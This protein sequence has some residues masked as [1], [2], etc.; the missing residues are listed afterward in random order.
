MNRKRKND[1]GG[2]N[3]SQINDYFPPL[4]R[5]QY[6]SLQ[7]DDEG[8]NPAKI[9]TGVGNRDLFNQHKNQKM[10]NTQPTQKIPP[11][12]II[13]MTITKIKTLLTTLNIT[14]CTIKLAKE[15][16]KAFMKTIGDY[17]TLKNELGKD[18][19]QFYTHQLRDEQTTKF[20]LHGLPKTTNDELTS[21]LVKHKVSPVQIKELSV[22]NRRDDDH[23]V[24][25]ISFLKKERKTLADM[26]EIRTIGFVR[27]RWEHY[28]NTKLGPT[29]CKNCMRFGHG[30][31]HCSLKPRCIRCAGEHKS[32]ECPLLIRDAEGTLTSTKIEWSKLKCALC[33][34]NHTANFNG[35]TKRAEYTAQNP[36]WKKKTAPKTRQRVEFQ[37]APQLDHFNFPRLQPG[38]TGHTAWA[39]Q[40]TQ[41]PSSSK[42]NPTQRQS[43]VEPQMQSDEDSLYSSQELA[44]IFSSMVHELSKAK[45][46]QQQVQIMLTLAAKYAVPQY[47]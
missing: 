7:L 11:I 8:G 14:D 36:V 15:G 25:L 42:P 17:N 13:G 21:E 45:S 22:K 46:K 31:T 3:C 41:G 47:G 1:M 2:G 26:N 23:R 40:A 18:G 39:Q 16:T 9:G 35:C 34:Q 32:Q 20:V 12:V 10:T 38:H 24:Y 5:N 30:T 4:G 33:G 19:H 44:E 37:H 43:Y 6:A 27:V 29:Q 28:R